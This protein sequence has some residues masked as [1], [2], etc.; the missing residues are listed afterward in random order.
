MRSGLATGTY[1]ATGT[2][3]VSL[4]N[5]PLPTCLFHPHFAVFAR[6]VSHAEHSH[7]LCAESTYG[8]CSR[9]L[10]FAG[11]IRFK[12]CMCMLGFCAGCLLSLVE[13]LAGAS[14]WVHT[15]QAAAA[16]S[17]THSSSL[18]KLSLMAE[19]AILLPACSHPLQLKPPDFHAS[20]PFLSF[21]CQLLQVI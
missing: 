15:G 5:Q 4:A 19:Q 20:A 3:T 7:P 14:L 2:Q 16:R 6:V 21:R 8:L 12:D 10:A 13:T 17:H 1:G 9:Q 18:A 11:C